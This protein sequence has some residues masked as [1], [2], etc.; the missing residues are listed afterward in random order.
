VRP[1]P[2]E[3]VLFRGHPSWRSITPFWLRGVVLMVVAGSMAGIASVVADNRV[4]TTWVVLGVLAVFALLCARAQIRLLKT[5]YAITTRRL[6]IETG[7]ISRHLRQ[8]SLHR[9]QHVNAR[10]S[11]LE[12]ALDVGTVEFD[13]LAEPEADFCFRGVED[14]R[15]LVRTVDRALYELRA[16]GSRRSR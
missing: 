7:L 4:Q 3:V 16:P 15:G 5:T 11:A 6:T 12:R 2:G 14:P 8:A 13:T 10:Q 9:V 1:E